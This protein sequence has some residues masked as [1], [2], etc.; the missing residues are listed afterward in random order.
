[1]KYSNWIMMLVVLLVS[2]CEM[3]ERDNPWDEKAS[4]DATSWSAD[5]FQIQDVNLTSKKLSWTYE[6]D[7]RIEGFQIDRRIGTGEWQEKFY[8]AGKEERE[9]ID[10]SIVPDTTK[11]YTY[12]LTTVAGTKKSNER[13]GTVAVR[14]PKPTNFSIQAN[15]DTSFTLNW[16][17]EATG[18]E[19]F[20]IDRRMGSGAWQQAVGKVVQSPFTEKLV[21]GHDYFYR[22]Y[23][24]YKEFN[25]AEDSDSVIFPQ[26]TTTAI[27]SVTLTTAVSGGTISRG[28]AISSRGL[29]WSTSQNPTIALSTKTSD[30]SGSGA[31]VSSLTGLQ[32]GTTYYVRAYATNSL[33]TGYGNQLS[34]ATT[35]LSVPVL[36]TASI[37]GVTYASASSGGN[38]TSDGGASVTARGVVWSTI[39]DPTI[40][41]STKTSNGTGT[42]A[43]ISN[44]TGLTANTT[45]YVRAYATNSQGTAYGAQVNF[46][47]T[48]ESTTGTVTSST[49]KVWM[50][51][52]L[53][54]SRV[55]T[56]STDVESYG[57]L[58]Q[59]GRN[60][61]G[62]ENRNSSKTS[63][64]SIN[65]VPGH[66]MFILGTSD[67]YDWRSPQNNNLW[68]GVNGINN[69]CPDGFRIPTLAE[70]EDE[71]ASWSSKDSNGAFASPLKL[72][73][74]GSRHRSTGT[75][76]GVGTNAYYWS[77]SI[78]GTK[79][80]GL[81]F[82]SDNVSVFSGNRSS[83][84]SVRCI[85]E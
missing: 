84:D 80:F 59:W 11:T 39:Q 22:I 34:F 12:R 76:F 77:A 54:A 49:G 78:D 44:I 1:M 65:D 63:S 67:Y 53:G 71:Y 26:I 10:T 37:T 2:T 43:F 33:G 21:L 24:Y 75:Q 48:A 61:D 64:L 58:Y 56:S 23:A 6:G 72:S 74:G 18:H 47:T 31:F 25:S 29:V 35:A 28:T 69:P 30:G 19:G 51:R 13:T 57:D 16:T 20:K 36:T 81:M 66:S 55:A 8:F 15:P 14:F 7:G 27:S 73:L 60:S 17:Y 82:G 52:N 70:W 40:S 45:Y 38:V 32:P 79:S 42:G 46:T 85:K 4:I 68:Q 9:W 62:H 3:P 41:L 83:G 5:G 50:D